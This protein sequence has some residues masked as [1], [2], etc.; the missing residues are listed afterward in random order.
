MKSRTWMSLA[1][2]SQ[3]AALAIPLQ[4]A[5][6]DNQ[7]HTHQHHHYQ[8]FDLGT[9]G[10]PNGGVNIEP[11]EPAL[12]SSGTVVGFADTSIPT[13]APGCYNPVANPDCYISHAFVWRD[14]VLKD[15][16][17]LPGGE[18][19]SFAGAI[20]QA[21]QIAGVSETGQTDP[22]TGNPEFHAVLW[23]H[24][25]IQDLGTFGGVSSVAA[26]LNDRGQVVGPALNDVPDPYSM[27]GLGS[28]TT[29]TQTRGFLWDHGTMKDLGTL[30]GSDTW[31]VYVNNRGQV[32]G[33]S[34]TSDSI[35]PNTGLPPIGVFLWEH[36]KMVDIGNLGGDNGLLGFYGIVFGL[37]NR[38]QVTGYMVMPG[39]QTVHAFLW[40]GKKLDDLG[41]LGGS[42]SWAQ[43]I[44]D[45]GEVV[46][47]S[48]TVGD[49][50]SIRL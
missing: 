43:R 45:N 11:W 13:S 12:N 1:V 49:R 6:Q 3:L 44:N 34:Y 16:E 17:T 33:T 20:N 10:G 31:P 48:L 29:L 26:D 37:N 47:N 30:G 14:G 8:F 7:A 2:I 5:A 46:G 40:D 32:A 35:D 22:A 18:E 21:G 19:F 4:L 42:A 27:L 38:G 15:L 23:H 9:F 50:G 25:K 24:D 41:T 28:V 39:D 36:G